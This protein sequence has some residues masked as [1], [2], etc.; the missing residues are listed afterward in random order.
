MTNFAAPVYEPD[1][2]NQGTPHEALEEIMEQTYRA[3]FPKPARPFDMNGVRAAMSYVEMVLDIIRKKGPPSA[4]KI[5]QLDAYT[6]NAISLNFAQA[7]VLYKHLKPHMEG[8]LHRSNCYKYASNNLLRGDLYIPAHPGARG[9]L[10]TDWDKVMLGSAEEFREEI[11]KGCRADG[12][13]YIG[14]D[15]Q[16]LRGTYLVAV[17]F[18]EAGHK[19]GTPHHTYHYVREDRDGGFSNKGGYGPVNRNDFTGQPITDPS[20][21]KFDTEGPMEFGGYFS[22]RT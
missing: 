6:Q 12:L 5:A 14:M 21:G 2:W 3:N 15:P 20:K 19:E 7:V 4:A 17:Y 11:I 18:G 8:P 1:K 13:K 22:A 16:N 10:K 9:N